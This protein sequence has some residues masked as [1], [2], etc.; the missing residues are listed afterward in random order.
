MDW[1]SSTLAWQLVAAVLA[2]V[3]LN[4]TPCVLPAIPVKI[5]TI[6]IRSGD[7]P[8]HRLAAALA[9]TSGTLA[10]F[11][12]L[13]MLIA[14]LHWNWGTLFQSPAVVM[15]LIV[16]LLAFATMTWFDIPLPVPAFSPQSPGYSYVEAFAS[17]LFSAVLAAPCAGPFLGG[18]LVFALGEPVPVILLVF[19]LI[20]F[21]LAVPYIILLL[22]PGLLARLPKTGVW[23]EDLRQGMAWILVAAAIFFSASLIPPAVYVGL[24]WAWLAIVALWSIKVVIGSQPAQRVLASV[25][26]AIALA[27]TLT[28]AMPNKGNA[29]DGIDWIAYSASR[30]DRVERLRQPH[31]VEFTAQWCINCKVLEETT[32]ASPAVVRT[33]T[34]AHIVPLQVDLTYSNPEG[35]A[36][37]ARYGGH[38]LPFAVVVDRRGAIV[39]RFSGLFSESQLLA[40]FSKLTQ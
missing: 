14:F 22:R 13:G 9:F 17:G 21:G 12:P 37:L 3:L 40:V 34:E 23:L 31:L 16:V 11:I 15:I 20:G 36:L 25:A 39:R 29:T 26:M 2:G 18:V 6:L 5:R 33:I 32:Y 7:T 8:G 10:L 38:A 4:L 28:I 35:E 1:I 24:W 19:V 30:L 27:L